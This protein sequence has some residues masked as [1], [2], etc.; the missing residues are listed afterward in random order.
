[1]SR[2]RADSLTHIDNEEGP[3]G[4]GDVRVSTVSSGNPDAVSVFA[5]QRSDDDAL[6]VMVVA[7]VLSGS[8][9]VGVTMKNFEAGASAS[10]WQ[11][12]SA[13]RIVQSPN[14]RV[15]GQTL[16]TS[17][18]AQSVT[19]VVVQSRRPPPASLPW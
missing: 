19:L 16:T 5:A 18:P 8:T 1:L 6:T 15:R 7:K 4:F 17:V 2:S 11:L 12:T 13:N 14:I 10:V 3:S 9:T